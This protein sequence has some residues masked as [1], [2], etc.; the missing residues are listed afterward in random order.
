M[1]RFRF[2]L[3]L[4][5]LTAGL[6]FVSLGPA[7]APAHA[8]AADEIFIE[9]CLPA[10]AATGASITCHVAPAD[11]SEFDTDDE[12]YRGTVTFTSSITDN[13]T[14]TPHN[15]GAGNEH[16]YTFVA[17]DLSDQG[18]VGKTFTLVFNNPG[19]GTVTVVGTDLPAGHTSDESEPITITGDPITTTTTT[20][21]TLAPTT[22]T[23]ATTTTTGL[24]TTTSTSRA[25][26]TTVAVLGRTGSSSGTQATAGA[27]LLALGALLV[28][29]ASIGVARDRGK[30]FA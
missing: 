28:A 27:L 15:A 24:G 20:S 16:K 8:A 4:G 6:G 25:T 21:T 18:I 22:T 9:D 19:T 13:F 26:T 7:V 23:L 1:R 30:H 10:T 12:G 29:A 2:V 5:L 11:S 3:A 17:G 14:V